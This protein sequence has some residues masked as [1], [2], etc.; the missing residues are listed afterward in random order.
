MGSITSA[1]ADDEDEWYDFCMKVGIMEFMSMKTWGCYSMQARW[2][3]EGYDQYKF[4]GAHLM[5]YIELAE[6]LQALVNSFQSRQKEYQEYLRLKAIY[7]K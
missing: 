7:E 6:K 1:I 2:A 5:E 3:R 4:T